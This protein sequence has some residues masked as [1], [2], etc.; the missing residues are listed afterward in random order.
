SGPDERPSPVAIARTL[1]E[2]ARVIRE[3]EPDVLLLQEVDDGGRRTD[4][5][6]QLARLLPMISDEYRCHASAFYWKAD[7]VPHARIRGAV[8]MKLSTIS[9]YQ[10]GDAT[11]H[12]LA[13]IP[14]DRITQEFSPKRAIL[15]VRLPVNEGPALVVMN[16]H[17]DAFAQGSDTMQQQ[18]DELSGLLAELTAAGHPWLIGGDFN[19]LPS[20]EAY[21]ALPDHQRVYFNPQTE[22]ADL[23]ERYQAVPSLAE[24]TGPDRERWFTHFPNDP[25]VSG[26]DRTIDYILLADSLELGNHYVRQHDTLAIADHFPLVVEL[27]LP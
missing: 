13:L 27:R 3:E 24:T 23:Y 16:T 15:E 26:P 10:I 9:K 5:E 6:D 11:R 7:F 21:R 18:V 17:L 12:Q 19:L 1:E 4:Y 20:P 14:A 22:L 2:V 8:G 25:A